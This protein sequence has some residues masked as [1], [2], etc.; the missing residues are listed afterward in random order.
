MTESLVVGSLGFLLVTFLYF[1]SAFESARKRARL[2]RAAIEAGRADIARE[3]VFADSRDF[4][5][6]CVR[7]FLPAD[8]RAISREQ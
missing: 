8:L 3:L 2:A 1:G 6:R 5:A 7:L 4:W